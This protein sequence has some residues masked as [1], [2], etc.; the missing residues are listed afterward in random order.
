MT[1]KK[2]KLV[3]EDWYRARI[4]S[5][6]NDFTE[7]YK[8]YMQNAIDDVFNTMKQGYDIPQAVE[9]VT[10]RKGFVNDR[11]KEL[12]ENVLTTVV[13]AVNGKTL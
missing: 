7:Q 1:V 11:L 5:A 12:I 2:P 13:K 3:Q 9:I 8:D 6:V 4:R 10:S